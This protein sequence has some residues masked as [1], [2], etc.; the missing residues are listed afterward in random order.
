MTMLFYELVATNIVIMLTYDPLPIKQFII[1]FYSL[2]NTVF[3][4]Y[5]S[6]TVENTFCMQKEEKA[7]LIYFPIN[8][9][10]LF[11]VRK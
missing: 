8:K 11:I 9:Q 2:P 6:L 1:R 10:L 4:M 7:G 3:L 5:A